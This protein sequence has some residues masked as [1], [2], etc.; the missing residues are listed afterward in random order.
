MPM[1]PGIGRLKTPSSRS[2]LWP[3]GPRPRTGRSPS[4]PPNRIPSIFRCKIAPGVSNRAR[5][6]RWRRCCSTLGNHHA[7]TRVWPLPMLSNV[8]AVWLAVL[9]VLPFSAPFP[10]CD[11]SDL[12]ESTSTGQQSN[13]PPI[14]E[15][16][17]VDDSTT[18]LV[19]PVVTAAKRLEETAHSELRD[20]HS[21]APTT[22]A[23]LSR[24]TP[25]GPL[26]PPRRLP[27]ILRL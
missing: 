16:T 12:L 20:V 15:R 27:A 7:T 3:R 5:P 23:P 4:A 9:V 14:S 8:C 10:T 18:L 25:P 6:G 17:A 11:L 26:V 21:V 24:V 19:P 1:R 2:A 22:I 13:R